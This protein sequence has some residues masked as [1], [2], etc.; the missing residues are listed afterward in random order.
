MKKQLRSYAFIWVIMLVTW[1][2]IVFLVRP[3]IPGYVITYD[4]RFWI[5]FVFII[6]AFIGNLVCAFLAF[7]AENLKKMFLN[8]PLITVSW[9]ALIAM[10]VAGSVLMLIPNCP[11]WIAAIV[12]LIILA[13]NAI[14]VIKAGWAA[15]AVNIVDEK[16][17]AKTS[18]VK[19]LVVD[20][21]NVL[22]RAKSDAE[23][24]ECKKVYEAV[25]YSDPMTNEALSVIEAKITEKAD[26][27]ASSVGVDNAERVKEIADE[28]VILVGDRNKKCR[29]LKGYGENS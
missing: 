4:A 20:I 24:A 28:I 9:S 1:C 15:D 26:E 11:A 5:A 23:K 2:A 13:F 22:S 7:K 14:A 6:A 21:E 25:R 8:L 10:L 27:F 29:A 19:N 17:K 12:C 18:F 3:I 16:V